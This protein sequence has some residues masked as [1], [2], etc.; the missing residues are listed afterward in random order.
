M[1]SFSI[2]LINNGS[3]TYTPAVLRNPSSAASGGTAITIPWV[4]NTLNGANN[5]SK[6]IMSAI[7]AGFNAL[8]DTLS[9]TEASRTADL[10]INIIDDGSQ[11]YSVNARYGGTLASGGTALTI[12]WTMNTL[13]G[14]STTSDLQSALM[15]VCIDAIVNSLSVS[16]V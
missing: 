3:G 4:E 10:F 7:W 8:F 14:A 11:N 13:N 9:A 15:R 16:G 1:A 5:S 12:P 2:N 6:V